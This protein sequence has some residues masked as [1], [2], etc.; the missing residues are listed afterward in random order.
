MTAPPASD[1]G[2]RS[3]LPV[4]EGQGEGWRP[5]DLAKPHPT[6]SPYPLT[7]TLSPWERELPA[8]FESLR[9]TSYPCTIT[10]V[11]EAWCHAS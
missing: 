6:D 3:P 4:G 5:L 9:T 2:L 10:L 8:V 7:P 11:T 1:G